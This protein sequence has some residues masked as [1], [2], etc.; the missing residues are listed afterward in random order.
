MVIRQAFK[1]QSTRA[2]RGVEVHTWYFNHMYA[3]V[4]SNP[5]FCTP[6]KSTH[7]ESHQHQHSSYTFNQP[8]TFL[9]FIN[10]M[11]KPCFTLA[12]VLCLFLAETSECFAPI[13]YSRP[14]SHRIVSIVS[15]S[16][17]TSTQRPVS[18]K[19]QE[20]DADEELRY[21]EWRRKQ[22][23]I[24]RKVRLQIQVDE[25]ER[26]ILADTKTF[27][28][29]SEM[30]RVQS[31]SP[32][33]PLDSPEQQ[34][35]QQLAKLEGELYAAVDKFD[36]QTA[37]K[38]SDE[39]S[40]LHIDDCGAVLQVNSA[41]YRAFTDK[42]YTAM[43]SI[44]LRD[45]NILCIHPSHAPLVGAPAVLESWKSMFESTVGS[46]QRN[47]MEPCNIKLVVKGTTAILTCDEEVYARRFVRGKKRETELMN[48]L[49]ATNI[50]RKVAGKWYMVHHHASWHA[51]SEVSKMA[52][53]G[54]A[55]SKSS[56]EAASKMNPA[57][58][59]GTKDFGPFLGNSNN[60]GGDKQQ[61]SVKK[62][63]MGGSLSDILNGSLGDIIA[64][65]GGD[66]TGAIIEISN[67]DLDDEDDD[68]DELDDDDVEDVDEEVSSFVKELHMIRDQTKNFSSQSKNNKIKSNNNKGDNNNAAP[69]DS[70]RQ[71]C[72][73]ALRKLADQGC[74]SQKQKRVLLTD[75]ITC[76]ARGEYS[77]V[78]VAYELLCGDEGDDQDVAEEEFADQCRVFFD[79]L[80]M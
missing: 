40:Q 7:S 52:L 76:S 29:Q 35:D 16:T 50:Y 67:L 79:S 78:E 48:K 71:N 31:I 63:I 22:E 13:R 12:L 44:W 73:T 53:N 43:E 69:Q 23:A 4:V 27:H 32:G 65:D 56:S 70:V 1:S 47:W 61:G 14:F 18:S 20:E 26:K 57:G 9:K 68:D 37:Q 11:S 25:E 21:Q 80:S 66:E 74:I 19:G 34:V 6:I 2:V 75:I 60:K 24:E 17:R 64:G 49:T 72:I 62:I 45:A 38:M 33:L 42:D 3:Y 41:F 59:L 5:K 10:I 77:M 39:I 54:G 46:F 36:C 15:T 30:K 28:L 51:D 58:I 55:N 8:L